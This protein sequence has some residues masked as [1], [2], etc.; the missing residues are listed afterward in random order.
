MHTH[1]VLC[2]AGHR[3]QLVKY[4]TDVLHHIVKDT[5]EHLTSEQYMRV[6]AQQSDS[7]DLF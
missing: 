5:W 1:W 6:L 7:V 4:H 2:C 3:M